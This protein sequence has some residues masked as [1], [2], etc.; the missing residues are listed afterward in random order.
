ME[1]ADKEA[2]ATILYLIINYFYTILSFIDNIVVFSGDS[3]HHIQHHTFCHGDQR[4]SW[5]WQL[6]SVIS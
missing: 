3:I 1:L 2:K 5:S 4:I 6:S